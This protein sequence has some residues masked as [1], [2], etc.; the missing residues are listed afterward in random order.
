MT[1]ALPAS[2]AILQNIEVQR[3]A[4]YLDVLNLMAYDFSGPWSAKCGH[5]AQLYGLS[6]DDTSGS[7]GV[8]YLMGQGF[9][10]NKI[11]LGIPLFGRSFLN[12]SGPG[13]KFKGAGGDDG[14]FEYCSLPRKGAKEQVD[15]RVV[16][17]QCVGGDGG[18]VSYDNPDT[19][20]TK[21]AFCKQKGL[22]VRLASYPLLA[23]Q[24][25]T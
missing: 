20:K 24:L 13:H 2:K 25:L 11:L 17:A 16:A 6:K 1:A 22:G 14:S 9:P 8:Q 15:K 4:D 18:F 7:A 23:Q 3:A 19:V 5:Q 21:A 10:S 12:T